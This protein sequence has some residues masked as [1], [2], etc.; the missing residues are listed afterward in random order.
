M[1][2][3]PSAP[4]VLSSDKQPWGLDTNSFG[5]GK[6]TDFYSSR[7]PRFRF[8]LTP[9]SCGFFSSWLL[10][11]LKNMTPHFFYGQNCLAMCL[12][13][14]F[15]SFPISQCCLCFLDSLASDFWPP[16]LRD[17]LLTDFLLACPLVVVFLSGPLYNFSS[18]RAMSEEG[19][20][21]VQRAEPFRRCKMGHEE[22]RAILRACLNNITHR[23]KF[24]LIGLDTRLSGQEDVL[25]LQRTWFEFPASIS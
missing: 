1:E 17:C 20:P 10:T 4:R 9:G 5:L 14:I 3:P 2:I 22:K 16:L 21:Q 19:W 18:S 11:K 7:I 15:T 8:P 24:L 6:Q 13:F 25:V 23:L 12:F